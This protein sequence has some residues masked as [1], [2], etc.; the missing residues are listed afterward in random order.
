MIKKIIKFFTSNKFVLTATLIFNIAIFI[1]V[2]FFINTLPYY[3]LISIIS[4]IATGFVLI[5]SKEEPEYKWPWLLIILFFPIYGIA[6]YIVLKISH[7]TIKQRR[8]WQEIQNITE[9]FLYQDEDV[10]KEIK[11]ERKIFTQCSYLLNKAKSPV[12]NNCGAYYFGNGENYFKAMLE[13]L[14]KAEKY[15][16]ME[17]FIIKP[18]ILWNQIEKVLI[19]RAANGVEV[20]LLY[21][22]FGCLDR[23]PRNYFK[24][25]KKNNISAVPF[26]KIKPTINPFINYRSH[27]KIVVI[28]GKTAFT[29]GLNIGDEYI[30]KT[31]PFGYWKDTGIML[32]GGAVYSFAVLFCNNWKISTKHTIDLNNYKFEKGTVQNGFV[33]P[34][35]SSPLHNEPIARNNLIRLIANAEK[36]LYVTTPYLILDNHIAEMLKLAASS[37]V[38]VRII[39]PGVPDKKIINLISKSYYRNLLEGGVKIYHFKPGFIH[40]KIALLDDITAYVGTVNFDFRSLFLHFEDAVMLYEGEVINEIAADFS[41]IFEF[42]EIVTLDYVK[43]MGVFKRALGTILRI[44]APLI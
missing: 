13:E 42:S 2:T 8:Q 16:F 34:F 36:Y 43:K 39:M 15:I 9:G 10:L 23:F 25:L 32:K 7:G 5:F 37:G 44:F 3:F 12:Y 14:N 11:E 1:S 31:S 6:F 21:D 40:A 22:D 33:Q 24:K 17:F 29:G 4:F 38:D 35:G 18:G 27:R 41:Q 30:N 19:E 20:K 26:N 28:D